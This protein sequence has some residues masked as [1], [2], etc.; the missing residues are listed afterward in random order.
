MHPFT[1]SKIRLNRKI[2][3]NVEAAE[4]GEISVKLAQNV[5]TGMMWCQR[6]FR[7]LGN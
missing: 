7:N 5:A 2:E 3:N 6:R 1:N 4:E